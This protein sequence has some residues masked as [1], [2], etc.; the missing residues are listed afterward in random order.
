MVVKTVMMIMRDFILK[1]WW[2]WYVDGVGCLRMLVESEKASICSSQLRGVPSYMLNERLTVTIIQ[3]WHHLSPVRAYRGLCYRLKC[4]KYNSGLRVDVITSHTSSLFFFASMASTEQRGKCY[5]LQSRTD[6]VKP[7]SWYYHFTYLIPISF[8]GMASTAC[9]TTRPA[10][11][12]NSLGIP[13]RVVGTRFVWKC[14]PLPL[15][16]ARGSTHGEAG[17]SHTKPRRSFHC[18]RAIIEVDHSKYVSLNWLRP[19]PQT[20]LIA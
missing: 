9:G 10:H 14:A 18:A 5:R 2:T 8:T 16:L 20:E 6:R 7:S 17:W 11:T 3:L 19:L 15:E 1:I 4:R 12:W 13:V